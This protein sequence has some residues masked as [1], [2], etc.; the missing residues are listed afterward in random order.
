MIVVTILLVQERRNLNESKNKI[1]KPAPIIKP[2][3]APTTNIVS[4]PKQ[5]PISPIST[6]T[7]KPTPN[8]I[9]KKYN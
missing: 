8:P 2:T 1:S 7:S 9:P 5:T 4:T 6:S 3:P